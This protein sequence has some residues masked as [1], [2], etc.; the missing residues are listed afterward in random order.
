MR[1]MR[2][3][4]HHTKISRY[5]YTV[6]A[7]ARAAGTTGSALAYLFVSE[8]CMMMGQLVSE[9]YYFLHLYAYSKCARARL[10]SEKVVWP[11][12][13]SQARP[14]PRSADRFQYAARGAY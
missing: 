4:L 12:L 7:H 13:V 5:I 1:S 11:K 14:F 9:A 6:S 2:E 8:I 10:V 3:I